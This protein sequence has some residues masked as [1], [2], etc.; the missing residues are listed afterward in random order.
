MN[1]LNVQSNFIKYFDIFFYF[2]LFF[3]Q[4]SIL[5]FLKELLSIFLRILI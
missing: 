4:G 1:N 2:I 3:D 5:V